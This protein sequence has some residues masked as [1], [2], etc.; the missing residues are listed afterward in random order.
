MTQIAQQAIAQSKANRQ[1]HHIGKPITVTLFGRPI[2]GKIIAVRPFGVVVIETVST[3]R[4]IAS[5]V[6]L[7][8][9]T[10]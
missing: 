8:E 7:S 5:G 4:V 3:Y 6:T 9:V 10:I 1:Q 2:T